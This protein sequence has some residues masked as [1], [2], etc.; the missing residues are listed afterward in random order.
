MLLAVLL[1]S[2]DHRPRLPA[3]GGVLPGA[4]QHR[5]RR[6]HVPGADEPRQGLVNKALAVF[7]IEGPG[8]LVDPNIALLSVAL[9]D[10]WKGVGLAT[11][12]YIAGIVAI[13]QEYFEAARVDGAGRLA[14]ASGTSSCRWLARPPRR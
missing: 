4:G 14:R 9:V 2:P 1:T 10:M 8:W 13:P 5:R 11:L 7:G 3:L 12:I 6:H